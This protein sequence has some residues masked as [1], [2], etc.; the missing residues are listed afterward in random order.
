MP[1][2]RERQREIERQ[3]KTERDREHKITNSEM[4]M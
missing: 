1:R 3:R 2:E 4:K